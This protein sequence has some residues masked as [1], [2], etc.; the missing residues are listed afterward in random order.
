MGSLCCDICGS[1]LT[2]QADGTGAVCQACGMRYG[3]D[4]L[5]A[6]AGQQ[7]TPKPAP[8]GRKSQNQQ[9]EDVAGYYILV[10]Q[11]YN[12][13]D[14]RSAQ[15]FVNTILSLLPDHPR[16]KKWAAELRE[17]VEDCQIEQDVF[18]KYRGTSKTFRVPP[19]IT[20]IADYAFQ[21]APC[22]SLL[23]P[24][25]I[26]DIGSFSFY[27]C[28]ALQAMV[29]PNHVTSIGTLA[30]GECL[31]LRSLVVSDSV[32]TIGSSA[33]S[34]CRTLESVKIPPRLYDPALFLD[35]LGNPCPWLSNLWRE[36][37]R[38]KY[39]GGRL[40][41]LFSPSCASCGKKQA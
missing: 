16:V 5:Q 10:K 40:K 36:S 18:V 17:L 7:Q 24:D 9:E 14:F 23:L 4:R 39:C 13:G 2:M 19:S 1:T 12:A 37:G 6:K 8:S 33:F 15:I 38:C 31:S 20:K 25:T 30:F 22:A 11:Y 28:T 34:G 32:R 29:I 21:N 3:L 41:G 35:V 26:T 27:G